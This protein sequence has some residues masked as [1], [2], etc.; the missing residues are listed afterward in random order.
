MTCPEYKSK[1]I[2]I[3]G[4]AEMKGLWAK[5]FGHQ[6]VTTQLE[7]QRFLF[8]CLFVL[9]KI[10][11]SNVHL[12][13]PMNGTPCHFSFGIIKNIKSSAVPWLNMLK[14]LPHKPQT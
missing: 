4:T 6:P 1:S 14:C 13:L 3:H 11:V 2:C 9:G 7:S 5:N 10:L 8:A 12:L